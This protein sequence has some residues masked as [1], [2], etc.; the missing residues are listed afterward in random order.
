VTATK[1]NANSLGQGLGGRG[2]VA[3]MPPERVAQAILNTIR[4]ERRDVYITWLDWSFV[5]A[6]TFW[7]SLMDWLLSR[8]FGKKYVDGTEGT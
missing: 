4:H 2:R 6:S 7:P 1:F 3:G 8:Y 5:T